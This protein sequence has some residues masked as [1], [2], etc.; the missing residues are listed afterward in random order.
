MGEVRPMKAFLAAFFLSAALTA[1]A[2]PPE[3]RDLALDEAYK[4]ALARSEELAA[5]AEGVKQL[6][7]AE[8][9][10]R[11]AFRPSLYGFASETVGGGMSGRAQAGVALDYNLFSGMRDYLAAKS[12]GLRSE[13]AALA[14]A[15]AR[16]ALYR[17]TAR[18]YVNL[19]EL[20]AEIRIR[21]E[22][23]KVAEGRLKEL[24]S[25]AAIGRSRRSEVVEARA[26]LAQDEASLQAALSDEE[27][28]RFTFAFITGLGTGPRLAELPVPQPGPVG[29]YLARAAGRRDVA[30]ARKAL[31]A[32]ESEAKAG[33]RLV[34]PSLDL[35]ADYYLKRPSPNEKKD[36]E[37][38]LSLKFPFYTGGYAS[39][40]AEQYRSRAE[41]ARLDLR[42][43]ER[44][45]ADEVGRAH[46]ALAR[47]IAVA[48]S[49]D[50]ALALA[51]ENSELQAADYK[52]GLV[53]NID[54]LNAQ[55]SVLQ[56]ALS[57]EQARARAAYAAVELEIA[58]GTEK[59]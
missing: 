49:L 36:W 10:I 12:A 53:T 55:N 19:Y 15:R 8:R 58:A 52:N 30:A 22:Q 2:Q 5:S 11:A 23:L 56:T 41:A 59:Q 34:W 35:S 13:A 51:L 26:R 47:A 29:N 14:L 50:K 21:R 40:A 32:A 17:D 45:A 37:A 6:E 24:E 18:A 43:A 54:V 28:A 20:G 16:E 31:E 27:G 9:Q 42:L 39:A 25:R 4:L 48:D 3:P 46:S 44:R 7:Y 1:A 38:A 57:L 33:D